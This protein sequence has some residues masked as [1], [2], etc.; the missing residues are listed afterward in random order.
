[1][2]TNHF[3]DDKVQKRVPITWKNYK[4]SVHREIVEVFNQFIAMKL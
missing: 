4:S 1:M 2:K 3:A